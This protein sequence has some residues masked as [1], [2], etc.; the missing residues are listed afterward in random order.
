MKKYVALLRGINVGGNN[1]VEMSKLR[2][3]F[4]SLGYKNVITYINSG[5][6]IF[7]TKKT[8][9]KKLTKEIEAVIKTSFNLDIR[10][11]L[12][13]STNIQK[14]CTS[15]TQEWTNDKVQRCDVLFLWDEFANKKST[16]FIE[17]NP[18]VD[19]LKYIDG[20]IVWHFDKKYYTKSK[21]HKFIGTI[22]YKHM[23]ARNINTVRKIASLM[24]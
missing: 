18:K 21:M 7:E 2:G 8:D 3:C 16:S 13:D 1:K 17:V 4:E 10:V 20:A 12:R 9:T 6:V 24:E 22:I 23:T 11:L 15:I 14:I 5:N 19:T